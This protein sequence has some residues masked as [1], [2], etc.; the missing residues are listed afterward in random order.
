M[1]RS[2]VNLIRNRNLKPWVIAINCA[3]KSMML[4]PISCAFLYSGNV[5]AQA[6]N[7]GGNYI[8][9]GHNAVT[10]GGGSIAIGG[11]VNSADA[12]SASGASSVAVGYGARSSAA[13]SVAVG[14]ASSD[15]NAGDV[16]LGNESV[17]ST[18]TT[19]SALTIAG[20]TYSFAGASPLS[21]VSVGA[22]GSEREIQNIA[23]GRIIA[24]STDAVNG[25]QL[26]GAISE[27]TK[28]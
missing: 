16:A 28:V 1:D 17:T 8:A 9:I 7:V 21:A 2:T 25:S 27:I 18:V 20:N 15:L 22:S 12:T 6:Y 23:A 26:Y 4:L 13:R 3:C 11:D 5:A 19:V 14:W 24:N 10:G